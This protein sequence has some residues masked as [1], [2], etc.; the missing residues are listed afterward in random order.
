MGPPPAAGGMPAPGAVPPP[1]LPGFGGMPGAAPFGGFGGGFPA[2][3]G[4]TQFDVWVDQKM[5]PQARESLQLT[6]DDVVEVVTATN[7]VVDGTALFRVAMAYAPDWGGRFLEVESCS[8]SLSSAAVGLSLAFPVRTHGAIGGVVHFC[9]FGLQNCTATY[10]LRATFHVDTYRKRDPAKITEHWATNLPEVAVEA[11]PPLAEDV[12]DESETQRF[13]QKLAELRLRLQEKRRRGSSHSSSPADLLAGS[14]RR[15]RRGSARKRRRSHSGS[16]SQSPES[17]FGD[18]PLHSSDASAIRRT[19]EEAPGRLWNGAVQEI[20]NYL[21]ARG[22]AGATDGSGLRDPSRFVTYLTAVFHGMFPPEK[23]GP[24]TTKERRTLAEALDCLGSGDLPRTAD[25]LV[26][27]F[28]SV[29]ESVKRGNWDDAGFLELIS[30]E[31]VGLTSQNERLAAQRG[32]LMEQ[33]LV[34]AKGA[35]P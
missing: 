32:L 29:E 28:K 5:S 34:K 27:R 35:A 9:R 15:H 10:G 2:P 23:V 31:H 12:P 18:A 6:Q 26:Q 22:G 19:S 30:R 4:E 16:R 13:E 24:R 25:L 7:A 3:Q 14:A 33:R 11:D 21:G 20:E 8:A 1:F 17:V